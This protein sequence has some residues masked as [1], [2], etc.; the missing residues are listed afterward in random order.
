MPYPCSLLTAHNNTKQHRFLCAVGR[1]NI[2]SKT[3]VI[4]II[5]CV[6]VLWVLLGQASFLMAAPQTRSL[7][8][9]DIPRQSA[10]DSLPAF[11]QQAD[12]TVMYAFEEA[13]QHI[14]NRLYGEYTRKEGIRILL[15]GSGLYARFSADGH[16]IITQNNQGNEM[17]SKKK[18]LAATVGFFMGAGGVSHTSAEKAQSA[19]GMDWLLEEVVVTAQKREQ[20]L[21][22]VPISITAI[23]GEDLD[24]ASIQNIADLSYAVPNLS[25]VEIGP[26]YQI[27]TI[28]GVGNLRGNTPTIGI[29]LD[30]IPLSSGPLYSLDLQ[31]VDLQQVEVLKGPQG[32]LYGQGSMGGT[33]RYITN[34]PSFDDVEGRMTLSGYDTHRGGWSEE[35]T[36]FVNIPVIDDTLAFRVSATYKDKPGWIDQPAAGV[37]DINDSELSNIRIKGLW[38]ATDE[39]AIKGNAI[40]HRNNYGAYSV[41]N[42]TPLKESNF[43]R[44]VFPDQAVPPGT[45]DYDLYNLTIAYDFDFATLISSSSKH[46]QETIGDDSQLIDFT[47][48]PVEAVTTTLLNNV[49][50]FTQDIRLTSNEG[51]GKNN[52]FDWTLGVFYNDAETRLS[53]D[54]FWALFPQGVPIDLRA[55]GYEIVNTTKSIA[56]YADASYA[57]T[58]QLTAGLG[59]RYFE[60]D[61]TQLVFTGPEAGILKE[62]SFDKLSSRV[63]LSY[64]W[65]DNLNTYFNVSQGFRSGGFN[66]QGQPNYDP[67]QI[68]AYELGTKSALLDNRLNVNFALFYS[69]YDDYITTTALPNDV[70]VGI[71][72]NVGEAVI[73]G[74]EWEFDWAVTDQ[75]SIG[76]NGA[77]TD[78]EFTNITSTAPAPSNIK[79]DL[80]PFVPEYGYSVNSHYSFNWSSAVAGDF[81][82]SYNREGQSA[83]IDRGQSLA[84]EEHPNEP[85]GFLDAQLSAQWQSL[86]VELF[87]QNLLDEDKLVGVSLSKQTA[88]HRPRTL[89]I[90]LS[91]DF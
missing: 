53:Y 31:V 84:V 32:T 33:I 76:F 21:I 43:R 83:V 42:T 87:G 20:R 59:T 74:L 89:G 3:D 85:F 68:L 77:V 75:L 1:G 10:D 71:T 47:F 8:Q 69:H 11:G 45:S 56:Y 66:Q 37:K 7:V 12:M 80:V 62:A 61:Q 55:G 23:S 73:K 90:R 17:N 27:V 15:K 44:G 19:E 38:Q 2:V 40:R 50:S 86:S 34:D 22:D 36:G 72:G 64:A 81:R 16:L 65:T 6:S 14:T 48:G 39:L 49:K 28:R 30:E 35:L 57:I 63:Y 25:T 67:E 26:G 46:E 24:V 18:I 88:Q 51:S 60:D 82:L 4:A 91:Y 78:A 52:L 54:A 13:N 41:V 5:K 9:F 79:G 70:T 58:S 29:Y